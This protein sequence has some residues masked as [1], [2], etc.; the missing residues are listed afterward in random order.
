MEKQSSPLHAQ[1]APGPFSLCTG[2]PGPFSPPPR[3]LQSLGLSVKLNPPASQA[4]GNGTKK[5]AVSLSI[6]TT[7]Y[8]HVT[9]GLPNSAPA[10]VS[11]DKQPSVFPLSEIQNIFMKGTSK[12]TKLHM[13]IWGSIFSYFCQFSEFSGKLQSPEIMGNRKIAGINLSL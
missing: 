4:W 3:L 5:R 7:L 1:E 9:Q 12:T 10:L 6:K 8:G 13:T 11:E 2:S